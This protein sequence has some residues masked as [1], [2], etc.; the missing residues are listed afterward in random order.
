VYEAIDVFDY[1]TKR[2]SHFKHNP[3][4]SASLNNGQTMVLFEDSKANLW[5]G[6][7]MGLDLLNKSSNSFIHYTTRNG[8]PN[9]SIQGI[10]EDDHGNLW[11]STNSGLSKFVRAVDIPKNPVF[12]N[13]SKEDGLSSNE[14]TMR[15]AY[16]TARGKCISAALKV[17]LLFSRIV[18]FRIVCNLSLFLPTSN[19]SGER[20]NLM[21]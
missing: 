3:D 6:T 16:K 18:L 14:F 1:E 4:D 17:I 11:I 20:W 19:F 15:S 9:N 13:Y 12:H 5:V 10:L 8:L 2:F 21:I 7:T